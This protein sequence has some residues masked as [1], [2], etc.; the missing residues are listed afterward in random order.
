[1]VP[2]DLRTTLRVHDPG[3]RLEEALPIARELVET[4]SFADSLR[5]FFRWQGQMV[6]GDLTYAMNLVLS[7]RVGSASNAVFET[8][9]VLR[10]WGKPFPPG[11]RLCL[12]LGCGMGFS[13]AELARSHFGNNC[14][15]VDL[16]PHFLVL[17]DKLLREHGITGAR[18]VCS[19]LD[20]GFPLALDQ[21]DVGF[22]SMDC[23]LEHLPDPD[24]V[25][26]HVAS[27]RS[28][29]Y[30]LYLTVPFRFSFLPESHFNLR[31]IGFMP[32]FVRHRYVAWRLGCAAER[33]RLYTRRGLLRQ[34]HRFWAPDA[35]RV[36][37]NRRN[38]FYRHYLIAVVYV[39]SAAQVVWRP[40]TAARGMR[41]AA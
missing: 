30:C 5:H 37:Y 28:Y 41:S 29:P 20:L 14:V 10:P 9:H 18:L 15:G 19:T 24:R 16:S 26:G 40:E 27:I 11:D 35:V 38:P 21:G 17:A 6:H 13:L 34:L 23:L 2:G 31:Y 33:V 25:L 39:E 7:R 12:D 36:I 4:G 32:D 8:C 1:V 3:C 22:I